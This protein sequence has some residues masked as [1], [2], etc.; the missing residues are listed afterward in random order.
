MSITMV[1]VGGPADGRLLTIPD[2]QPPPLY[3]IPLVPPVA[4]LFTTAVPQPTLTRAAEYEPVWENG[5]PSRDDSGAVRYRY[6]GTPAPPHL[7]QSRPTPNLDELASM[8]RDPEPAAYST[9]A[10]HLLACR[11]RYSLRRD[12]RLSP[13]ERA[14]TDAVT[15]AHMR[16]ALAE[17]RRNT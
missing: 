10:E 4:E 12:A 13:D 14:C 8:V 2:D 16:A 5:W 3:L 7:V 15:L 9:S 1:F 11:I 6:R 17:R